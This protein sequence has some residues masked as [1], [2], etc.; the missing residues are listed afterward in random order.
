[1]RVGTEGGGERG[2]GT[3]EERGEGEKRVRTEV[4]YQ[5]H[6]DE[7]GKVGPCCVGGRT[8]VGLAAARPCW[9]AGGRGG[10]GQSKKKI[11]SSF[12][13]VKLCMILLV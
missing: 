6:R 9:A 8:Q 11:L 4:L 2:K 13:H 7:S 3:R 10:E 5:S 12:I 1:M